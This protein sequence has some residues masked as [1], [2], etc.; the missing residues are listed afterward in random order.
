LQ[1]TRINFAPKRDF[2]TR[3]DLVLILLLAFFFG[4]GCLLNRGTGE[5]VA[6]R[7]QETSW[8]LPLAGP[9][10]TIEVQGP[11]GKTVVKVGRGEAQVISSPCPDQ[12]CIHSG[13]ITKRGQGIICAPN[14]VSVQVLGKGDYHALTH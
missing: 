3:A 7:G 2:Y 12:I 6:V 1:D 10:K 9:E 11:L 5:L 14:H 8:Q 13:R 4:L